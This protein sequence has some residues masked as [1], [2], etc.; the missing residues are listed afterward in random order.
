MV[1]RTPNDLSIPEGLLTTSKQGSSLA[2][3]RKAVTILTKGKTPVWVHEEPA[4]HEVWWIWASVLSEY[5][6]RKAAVTSNA[7]RWSI[8]VHTYRQFGLEGTCAR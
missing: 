5:R 1:A 6:A 3:S 8:L 7:G 2:A 4:A